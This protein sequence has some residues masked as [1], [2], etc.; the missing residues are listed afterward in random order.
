MILVG[1]VLLG[2][3]NPLPEGEEFFPCFLQSKSSSFL[4]A[5]NSSA[6]SIDGCINA[7]INHLN[8]ILLAIITIVQ[9]AVFFWA[10]LKTKEARRPYPAATYD[11]IICDIGFGSWVMIFPFCCTN[12][13]RRSVKRYKHQV[14]WDKHWTIG[15]ISIVRFI[16]EC[17]EAYVNVV[18]IRMFV[19]A[20]IAA[21]VNVSWSLLFEKQWMHMG[22]LV[23][24]LFKW[25]GFRVK[26]LTS[27]LVRS[28]LRACDALWLVLFGLLDTGT[29]IVNLLNLEAIHHDKMFLSYPAVQPMLI[30]LFAM[31]M[32]RVFVLVPGI[33][34]G[35]MWRDETFNRITPKSFV[36]DMIFNNYI[37]LVFI[38]MGRTYDLVGFRF[39]NVYA[40]S[41]N[42][43]GMLVGFLMVKGICSLILCGVAFRLAS[44][45]TEYVPITLGFTVLHMLVSFGQYL[46]HRCHDD[47]DDDDNAVGVADSSINRGLLPLRHAT[48]TAPQEP[49]NREN[50]YRVF[51]FRNPY[52]RLAVVVMLLIG[53]VISLM[54]LMPPSIPP[55][56]T[57]SVSPIPAP[58]SAPAPAHHMA[59]PTGSNHLSCSGH[60]EC[61]SRV[62]SQD[63]Y[64]VCKNGWSGVACATKPS[65]PC[66][67]IDCGHGKCQAVSSSP[68]PNSPP[69]GSTTTVLN[70]GLLA[71]VI[72]LNL[73]VI[74]CSLYLWVLCVG[75]ILDAVR[76]KEPKPIYQYSLL[77]FFI[78]V[79][80]GIITHPITRV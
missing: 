25:F 43:V 56:L 6:L 11:K 53:Y 2:S 70:G 18:Q 7:N 9:V 17:L 39:E 28:G 34:L 57:P 48:P 19:E 5:S 60:G 78:I 64:C 65:S 74:P 68:S 22:L 55:P 54:P 62:T 61:K 77:A 71:G 15:L 47:D 36:F 44:D 76:S 49:Y 63:A 8:M 40:R 46:K 66:Y 23:F 45:F 10:Y 30:L 72:I 73:I 12:T 37:V 42:S 33:L 20:Q 79:P 75:A 52:W 24:L 59:C 27:T 26:D 80:I 21:K 41:K 31:F 50:C 35:V 38:L 4:N 13:W 51:Q 58:A 1:M 3:P 29:I 16:S 69:A 67:G 32:L 14:Y